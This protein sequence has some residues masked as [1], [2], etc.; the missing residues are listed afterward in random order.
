MKRPTCNL[1]IF[2]C[3]VFFFFCIVKLSATEK[4]EILPVLTK[5]SK[6]CF[7][8]WIKFIMQHTNNLWYVN[9]FVT[10]ESSSAI[11]ITFKFAFCIYIG[12]LLIGLK[13][14]SVDSKWTGSVIKRKIQL[15]PN[16]IK[17]LNTFYICS[18][19]IIIQ[20]YVIVR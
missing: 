12:R 19:F 4:G 8:T 14:K 2:I 16:Q 7:F 13:I 9:I 6:Y 17:I 20:S 18:Q 11:H 10:V 5:H 1:I 15:I 3:K